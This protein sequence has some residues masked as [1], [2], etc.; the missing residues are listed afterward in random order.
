MTWYSSNVLMIVQDVGCDAML[1]DQAATEQRRETW[2]R[3]LS[4]S[5][6]SSMAYDLLGSLVPR[7]ISQWKLKAQMCSSVFQEGL[8]HVKPRAYEERYTKARVWQVSNGRCCALRHARFR[9]TVFMKLLNIKRTTNNGFL[10]RI[11]PVT[12][13]V[14][15]VN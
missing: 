9:E 8:C 11:L 4:A 5:G 13:L 7:Y 2:V 14:R 12:H 1:P 15:D 3:R 6:M 10:I